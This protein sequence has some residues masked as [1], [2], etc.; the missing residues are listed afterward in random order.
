[1]NQQHNPHNYGQNQQAPPAAKR[2]MMYVPQKQTP[3]P[4]QLN[5]KQQQHPHQTQQQLDQNMPSMSG[6]IIHERGAPFL[7]TSGGQRISL[8][9]KPQPQMPCNQT[10]FQ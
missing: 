10:S 8:L 5:V 4:Q 7:L 9:S 6:T 1:M 3:V 2:L